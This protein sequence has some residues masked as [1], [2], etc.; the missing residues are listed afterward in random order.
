M[1]ARSWSGS[2]SRYTIPSTWSTWNFTVLGEAAGQLSVEV[3][4]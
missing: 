4:D 2:R 3:K 1:A